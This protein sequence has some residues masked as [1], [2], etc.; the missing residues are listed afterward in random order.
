M[1]EEKKPR[2]EISRPWRRRGA[3]SPPEEMARMFEEFFGASWPRR[4]QW[5]GP[6]GRS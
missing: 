5:G 6:I 2:K 3:L 4:F 1:A